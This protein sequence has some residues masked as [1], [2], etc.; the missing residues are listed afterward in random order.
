M[1]KQSI[2]Y[3][4]TDICCFQCFFFFFFFKISIFNFLDFVFRATNTG[5]LSQLR[6]EFLCMYSS[7]IAILYCPVEADE[8]T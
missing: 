8:L 7:C 1:I 4:D 3:V 2:D 5:P 6:Y